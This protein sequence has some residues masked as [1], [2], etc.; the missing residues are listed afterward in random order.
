MEEVRLPNVGER[1]AERYTIVS[2]VSFGGFGAVY[3]AIQDTLGREV[4][5]KV[6]LP[7]I[8]LS[9][10]DY[11]EQFRQEA[12]LTS[13]LRHP[14]TITIFDYGQTDSN[15]LFLVMEWLDGKTL[16]DM[17]RDEGAISYDRCYNIT[18]QILKSLAEAH[19]RGM[20]HRDLKPSNLFLCNQYGEPDFVKVLDF[21]LV[22]NLASEPLSMKGKLV[23]PPKFTE[24][25][26]APGTPHYMAPE[27]ATGKG[28]T[29][30][31]DQYSF[32]L[33]LHEMLT[34]KRAVDGPDKMAVLLRQAREPV[35]LL[36]EELQQT[37]LGKVV[38]RCVEKDPLKRPQ[39][40]GDLLR[41]YQRVEDTGGVEVNTTEIR[42]T[43]NWKPLAQPRPVAS[44]TAEVSSGP[45][46]RF[47]GRGPELEEFEDLLDK[48]LRSGRGF[49]MMLSGPT[50]IGK[51]ALTNKFSELFATKGDVVMLRGGFLPQDHRALTGIRR[52]LRGLLQVVSLEHTEGRHEVRRGLE[53]LA[54]N[55]IYLLN[56]LSNFIFA[57]FGASEDEKDECVTRLSDLLERIG[58]R[59]PL[60]LSLENLQWADAESLD[61]LW[62]LAV[63]P[64]RQWPMFVVA[65]FRSSEY[66]ENRELQL[67]LERLNR[68]DHTA[69]REMHVGALGKRECL[70]LIEH[71]I[72]MQRSMA[73]R[74]LALS[75]GNPLFLN[76]V[77]RYLI[78]EAEHL[79]RQISDTG[80]LSSKLYLPSSLEKISLRRVD[81]VVRKYGQATFREVLRRAALVGESFD[82]VVLETL[83]RKEGQYELL[84]RLNRT[85][86]MWRREGVL[87]RPWESESATEFVHPHMVEFFVTDSS[88]Q[89]H[90]IAARAKE[91]LLDNE[92]ISIDPADL[93]RHYQA[94]GETQEAIR[95]FEGAAAVA[96]SRNNFSRG[97]ELYE[98]LLPLLDQQ[99]AD[100][101][102]LAKRVD[103]E[104]G[105]ICLRLSEFGPSADYFGRALNWAQGDG[106][107]ALEGLCFCGKADLALAQNQ[108]DDADR[109]FHQA[110]TLLD[111]DDKQR[112]GRLLLGMGRVSNLKGDWEA[113]QS[114]FQRAYEQGVEVN[115]T[116]MIGQ[117][118][119]ELGRAAIQ[120]GRYRAGHEWLGQ[121]LKYYRENGRLAEEADALLDIAETTMLYQRVEDARSCLERAME[122]EQRLGDRVGV[123]RGLVALGKL[124]ASLLHADEAQK[125]VLRA[126][127]VFKEH[128]DRAGLGMCQRVLSRLDM[129]TGHLD[130][131][132]NLARQALELFQELGRLTDQVIL[133]DRL[134]LLALYGGKIDEADELFNQALMLLDVH[135]SDAYRA[136]VV[137]DLAL[138]SE[139]LGAFDRA[140]EGYQ[141]AFEVAQRC[142]W[143][144][145]QYLSR[146]SLL[147]VN[148]FMQG[149]RWYYDELWEM[150][151]EARAY[152]MRAVQLEALMLL[153]WM[154]GVFG[155][156]QG[157]E[158]AI[159]ELNHNIRLHRVPVGGLLAPFDFAATLVHAL[160]Q[161]T[162]NRYHQSADWLRKSISNQSPPEDNE[163]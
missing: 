65:T 31:A 47:V 5:I 130:K 12:L 113:A 8:F 154:E 85:L 72:P 61:L 144:E 11:V 123:A 152:G 89:L 109:F 2:R 77:L 162:A 108:L 122:I 139:V 117:A 76:L 120:L 71:A 79:S 42:T 58:Q 82:P 153:A 114:C 45:G 46:E 99:R 91:S 20:V 50:G 111:P 94:A 88:K 124:E 149:G 52:A 116:S 92:S 13:Q 105:G 36:P 28:T 87:R 78:D 140:S 157:W 70:Q 10:K 73:N 67:I 100:H 132:E 37:F 137:H 155:D 30:S 83:L 16:S 135:S 141:A 125:S 101:R 63:G 33:I 27:Q 25:R 96:L 103:F 7:E 104:L 150:A 118:L 26:R 3:K 6:L 131:A 121:A 90:L 24:K 133:T 60:M 55:D 34:G 84:D 14:N 75:K 129:L 39:K 53:R 66:N 59:Q 41:E 17:L 86:E 40:A 115:D 161:E 69:Y 119:H 43:D 151:H 98:E 110:R 156:Q 163:S 138:R 106:D 56:F 18:Y 127:P 4:A 29:T 159:A 80:A 1:L 81:Q 68:L 147:K 44:S 128:G 21:G 97:K 23:E 142:E 38:A 146:I 160:G 57:N 158:A 64:V 136:V 74:C 95:H 143:L 15:L 19:T 148:I 51:T 134:G 32:G 62:R 49:V 112:Q 102:T 22:K 93:A 9:N 126:L 48:R 145:R 35:P 54:I 107:Q